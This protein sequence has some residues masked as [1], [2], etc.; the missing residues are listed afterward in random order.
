MPR[1]PLA[2]L[3]AIALPWLLACGGDDS[4]AS[5]PTSETGLSGSSSSTTDAGTSST[6]DAS[7]SGS[8]D[9]S[10]SSTSTGGETTG[11]GTGEATTSTS[12]TGSGCTP[13]EA[14]CACDGNL[15]DEGLTCVNG[16]CYAPL[17]CTDE[18]EEPNNSE[19]TAIDLGMI[20]DNDDDGSSFAGVLAGKADV[21]W[22]RYIGSDTILHTTEPTRTVTGQNLRFCK[23]LECL[24]DG[25]AMTDVTCPDGTDFAISPQLRPGCCSS[26]GFQLSDYNCPGSDDSVLVYM[27]LDKALFDECVPYKVDYYL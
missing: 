27:R 18:E 17:D 19:S 21:D 2:P 15:C 4:S 22:Y 7:G 25:P 6:S 11:V 26:E 12:T 20:T 24:G 13:G 3:A 5:T 23:F 9:A 16:T 14:G 10:T 1:L 8:G